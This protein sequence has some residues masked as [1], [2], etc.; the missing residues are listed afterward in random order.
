MTNPY[1]PPQADV[2]VLPNR[3]LDGEHPTAASLGQRLANLVIDYVAYMVLSMALGVIVGLVGAVDWVE[4]PL[5]N[6]F[7]L[8]MMFGYYAIF[9]AVFGRT[10]G[11]FVTRT[12]VVDINGGRASFGQILGRTALRFV[13]FEPFSFFGSGHGWHD[14]WSNT[15][16]VRSV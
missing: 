2:T 9:E 12:R 13:P 1:Q 7:G 8:V 5:G 16:V 14:R 10:P 6:L 15:R 3:G 4:S 11:K